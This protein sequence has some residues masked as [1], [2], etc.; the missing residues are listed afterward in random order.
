MSGPLAPRP[1]AGLRS[2]PFVTNLEEAKLRIWGD[3]IRSQLGE[4]DVTAPAR[5]IKVFHNLTGKT[6]LFGLNVVYSQ[7]LSPSAGVPG[8]VPLADGFFR[9]YMNTQLD[10]VVAAHAAGLPTPDMYVQQLIVLGVSRRQGV[11]HFFVMKANDT[12]Y[13]L[14]DNPYNYLGADSA[15][16]AGAYL[17]ME[18]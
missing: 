18:A 10:Q 8:F 7:F 4:Y 9:T 5:M 13:A 17:S 15:F 2:I 3:G 16:V 6:I 14:L 12:L 11:D 1:V